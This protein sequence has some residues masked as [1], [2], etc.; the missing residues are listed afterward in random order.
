MFFENNDIVKY[1]Q[2]GN[3]YK[4]SQC[5]EAGYN[6]NAS[7]DK[8]NPLV[9]I[10]AKNN[11]QQVFELLV[12]AGAKLDVLDSQGNSSLYY[13]QKNENQSLITFIKNLLMNEKIIPSEIL[14]SGH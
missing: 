2:D 9:T 7:D 5:I 4:V 3:K 10:A 13:A 14:F 12:E 8:K 6:V 11:N 1:T